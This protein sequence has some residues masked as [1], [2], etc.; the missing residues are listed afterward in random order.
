MTFVWGL[1]TCWALSYYKLGSQIGRNF[2]NEFYN[3][4]AMSFTDDLILF[5]WTGKTE[6]RKGW[7]WT[8]EDDENPERENNEKARD[9]RIIMNWLL[10]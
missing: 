7:N 2:F 1:N 4:C 8:G 10:I 5:S 6:R 3:L 9:R